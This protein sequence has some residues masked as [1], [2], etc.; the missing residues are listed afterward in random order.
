MFDALEGRGE[1]TPAAAAMRTSL[2]VDE[3]SDML[4]AEGP[5]PQGSPV[6]SGGEWQGS[7]HPR[8]A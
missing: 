1:L 3:A 2:T 8:R 4:K 6:P 7:L 5:R